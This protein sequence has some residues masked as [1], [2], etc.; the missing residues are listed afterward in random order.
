[1]CLATLMVFSDRKLI[2]LC[3]RK[4]FHEFK[5]YENLPDVLLLSRATVSKFRQK[6]LKFYI[7][8]LDRAVVSNNF[9]IRYLKN[10]LN[11][12]KCTF[13]FLSNGNKKKYL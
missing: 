6:R 7:L 5:E 2:P 4:I 10:I 13:S 8:K 12:H 11:I 9:L 1:M 3:I